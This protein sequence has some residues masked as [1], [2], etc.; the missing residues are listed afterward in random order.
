MATKVLLYCA[1]AKPYLLRFT[2]GNKML[3]KLDNQWYGNVLNGKIVAECEVECE[4]IGLKDQLNVFAYWGFVNREFKEFDELCKNSCFTNQELD[5]Y[6]IR[7]GKEPEGPEGYA[8]H[9]SNL[10]VFNRPLELG[11]LQRLKEVI[12]Q[13]VH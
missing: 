10:N 1:K 11:E 8:S 6:L 5:K 2:I 13:L 9:I 4:E 7:E 3:Y 12:S